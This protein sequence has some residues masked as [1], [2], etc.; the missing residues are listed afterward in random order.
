[1]FVPQM[2]I[3]CRLSFTAAG[4]SVLTVMYSQ[5]GVTCFV[6]NSCFCVRFFDQ[7]KIASFQRQLSIYGFVVRWHKVEEGPIPLLISV[8]LLL[9]GC[10]LVIAVR[11]FWVRS[12][13]PRVLIVQSITMSSFFVLV[14]CS[15]VALSAS[16]SRSAHR[17]ARGNSSNAYAETTTTTTF[18]HDSNLIRWWQ[19]T[20]AQTS[21]KWRDYHHM[22]CWP[23]V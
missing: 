16:A 13:C 12:V 17:K 14:P 4:S 20:L 7:T 19:K 3:S 21:C 1:M 9:I 18:E 6:T 15:A 5:K 8:H 22:I 2:Y 11:Y 10:F 23:T